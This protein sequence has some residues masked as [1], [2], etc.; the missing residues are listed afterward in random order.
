VSKVHVI[1]EA[2]TNHNGDP[3]TAEKLIGV[4][5]DAGADSV[6]FQIIY[7]EGLYLPKIPV[8]GGYQEN[9]V[10]AARRKQMISEDEWRRLAG[11]ARDRGILLSAS[12]FDTQG[13]DLL[14]EFDPPYFKI[15]STDLNNVSFVREVA[16]RGRKV[17]LS[18][19]MST[20]DEVERSVEAALGTGNS[21]LVLLHCVS[22]YPAPLE[23]M[24]LGYI[25]VLRSR[26]NLPI[27]LSDHTESSLAAAVAISKGATWIEKHFTLDRGSE[28][29]DHA[30]AMEPDM[31][32]TYIADV[33]AAERSVEPPLRKLRD[34]E[35]T[36]MQRARRAIYAATDL[37]AGTVLSAENVIVVRPEGPLNAGDFDR[38]MGSRLSKPLR[39][40]EAIAPE[41]LEA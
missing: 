20:T 32:A 22:V 16:S 9:E 30:Y 12:V 38:V 23:E 35:R 36:V 14:E 37:E 40:Y 24:N 27:G 8:D 2:G 6:K 39:Q 31:L 21:D 17:V 34:A 11:V 15:A 18:T 13:L 3:A 7:P 4:A 26:F 33:R 41:A 1:A 25:D 10:I 28:G 19:G 29:F 5:A